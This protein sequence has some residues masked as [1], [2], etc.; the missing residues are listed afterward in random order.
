MKE[1]KSSKD[2]PT[3]SRKE[4]FFRVLTLVALT[5]AGAAWADAQLHVFQ[6]N[7]VL[8]ASDLNN[9]FQALRATTANGVQYSHMGTFCGLSPAQQGQVTFPPGLNGY[10]AAKRLCEVSCGQP[11]AHLCTTEEVV[12][13]MQMDGTFGGAA[14]GGGPSAAWYAT[15]LDVHVDGVAG[16][17]RDCTGFTST[18]GESLAWDIAARFSNNASCAT[19]IPLLCCN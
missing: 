13:H 11:T 4:W 3:T 5:G 7:D 14:D 6:A 19:A 10:R 17:M 9:N 8:T 18:A 2:W 1:T 16:H 12:R 15:G